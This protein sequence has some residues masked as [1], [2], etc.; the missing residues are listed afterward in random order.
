LADPT[1]RACDERNRELFE[2]L[3]RHPTYDPIVLAGRWSL[4]APGPRE[5]RWF[6]AEASA[7]SKELERRGR[8]VVILGEVPSFR[9]SPISCEIRGDLPF[10]P[11]ISC[12]TA[13]AD[14]LRQQAGTRNVLMRTASRSADSCFVD[15]LPV[16]CDGD[17]CKQKGPDDIAHYWDN[18][19]L[20]KA[21]AYRLASSDTLDACLAQL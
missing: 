18:N 19:H 20:N 6:K 14:L 13:V 1:L 21:G 7:L 17:L 2:L 12:D 11:K 9:A 16:L 3:D 8:R 5:R 15:P 10:A 4:Y